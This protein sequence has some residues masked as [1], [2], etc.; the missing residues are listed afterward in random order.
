MSISSP[1]APAPCS[2]S[3]SPCPFSVDGPAIRRSLTLRSA[4]PP[5]R[6]PSSP[7]SPLER[8]AGLVVGFGGGGLICVVGIVILLLHWTRR[9]T[10]NTEDRLGKPH[11]DGEPPVQSQ[12]GESSAN[13]IQQV[14]KA[15]PRLGLNASVSSS[16][17]VS[18]A[19]ERPHP[20]GIFTY[21][22]LEMATND[23]SPDNLLG[24]GGFGFVYKGVL[25]N[26]TAVAIKQLKAGSVQGEPEFWAEVE[27]VGRVHH[28]HLV[29]LVGYCVSSDQRLLVYEFV[30]NNTLE[31][32]LHGNGRPTMNWPTRMKIALGSARGLA[33]LHEDCQPKIIHRDIK[34]A[35]IL[36]EHNFEAKVADFGLAKFCPD[37]DTHVL[38]RIM[39]TVGYIAP[40]FVRTGKLTYKSDV[41]SFGVVLLELISGRRAISKDQPNH[42]IVNWAR[43]LLPQALEKSYFNDLVDPMLQNDYNL[44]EMARMVACAVAC[45]CHSDP[46][47]PRMGQIVRALEGNIPLSDLFDG[48]TPGQSSIQHGIG[49]NSQYKEELTKYQ[50]LAPIESIDERSGPCNDLGQQSCILVDEGEQTRLM[51]LMPTIS[52]PSSFLV[53]H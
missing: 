31:F 21:E 28:R 53:P 51:G 17:S 13:R 16:M 24:Q 5:S 45:V 29:S 47:R 26:G 49:G 14:Q 1:P 4:L 27:V 43:A 25:P 15:V 42:N 39:G 22:E 3:W 50:K 44:S 52:Q 35:N 33:Y 2:E 10:M 48:V 11:A 9:T 46:H 18:Y 7:A 40:E 30:P 36:L 8:L 23:F 12:S 37:P 20:A 6:P 19:F 41:Y 34:A 38:T 32:Q